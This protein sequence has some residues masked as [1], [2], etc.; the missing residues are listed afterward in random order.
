MFS[1]GRDSGITWLQSTELFPTTGEVADERRF[2]EHERRWRRH[3]W[4]AKA[5][6][7]AD[8][9]D[10][11]VEFLARNAAA[12]AVRTRLFDSMPEVLDALDAREQKRVRLSMRLLGP[13]AVRFRPGLPKRRSV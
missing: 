4:L 13:R 3:T 11:R 1:N 5:L 2:F 9:E 6:A 12:L 10:L 7:D 8:F